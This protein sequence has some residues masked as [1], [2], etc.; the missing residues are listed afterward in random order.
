MAFLIVAAGAALILLTGERKDAA[1]SG[2]AGSGE[3][4]LH[5]AAALNKLRT[6]RSFRFDMTLKMNIPPTPVSGGDNALKGPVAR[7][8]PGKLSDFR[9]EGAFVSP[10]QMDVKVSGDGQETRL[11]QIGKDIWGRLGSTWQKLSGSATELE[12]YSPTELLTAFVLEATLAGAKT[13]QE[14]VNGEKTTRYS[15]DKTEVERIIREMGGPIG[16]E[17]TEDKLDVWV[18]SENIPVKIVMDAAGKET[19]GQKHFVKLEINLRDVNSDAIKIKA[20][21]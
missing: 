5:L 4:P 8:S 21:I 3:E 6:L 2:S 1:V 13:G 7:E 10:D 14:T 12:F 18:T 19:S 16:L 9:A 11:I 17:M 15:F 20:P